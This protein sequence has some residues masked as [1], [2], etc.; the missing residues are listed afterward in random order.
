MASA[1]KFSSVLQL[2]DLDDFITPSQ[3]L[4]ESLI[5][6]FLR[7]IILKFQECVRPVKVPREKIDSSTGGSPRIRI[8]NE[9]VQS[10]VK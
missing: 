8:G 3:V 4:T 2:Q 5:I 6:P 9:G 1:S 7:C 10:G